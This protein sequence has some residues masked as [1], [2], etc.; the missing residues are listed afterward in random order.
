VDWP[1]SPH[2][3]LIDQQH[4]QVMQVY[5][6]HSMSRERPLQRRLRYALRAASAGTSGCLGAVLRSRRGDFLAG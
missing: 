2:R 3:G 4:V 5:Q 6:T 1:G